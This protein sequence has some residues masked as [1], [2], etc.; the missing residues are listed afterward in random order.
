M[1]LVLHSGLLE[2]SIHMMYTCRQNTHTQK[3]ERKGGREEG[4]KGRKKGGREDGRKEGRKEG[5][6]EG[7]KPCF[8]KKPQKIKIKKTGN[9]NWPG[10]KINIVE[11]FFSLS[12]RLSDY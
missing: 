11:I 4:R 6:N 5:R 12:I 8:E 10:S 2:T 7:E 3:E 1:E 9:C